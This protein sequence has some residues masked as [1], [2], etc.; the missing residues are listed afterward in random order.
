MVLHAEME[1]NLGKCDSV[2]KLTDRFMGRTMQEPAVTDMIIRLRCIKFANDHN[3]LYEHVI[4]EAI[5]D[6]VMVAWQ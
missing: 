2:L 5:I 3:E 1:T 6:D 4:H